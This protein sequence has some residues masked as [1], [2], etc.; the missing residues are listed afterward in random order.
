MILITG[1]AG[2]IG[3]HLAKKLL[4][5]KKKVVGIDCINNYYPS[6][7]KYQRIK[8]IKKY[9][10]FKFLKVKLN[11]NN[12]VNNVIRKY[13]IE[14]I[15]H[16]AA[17]PGVRISI[18]KPHNTLKQNL[19]PFLNIIEISRLKKVKKFIYASSS[20]VYGNSTIYPFNEKDYK[21]IPV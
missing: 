1:C 21:N 19:I 3:F 17:Q 14:V 15:I 9:D 18:Q 7:K 20:S 12:K 13:K 11:D 16:L 8:I 6:S 4:I 10:K 2:F 5:N